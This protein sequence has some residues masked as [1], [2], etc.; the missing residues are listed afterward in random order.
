LAVSEC[1]LE[2]TQFYQSGAETS[3]ISPL[4]LAGIVIC[5]GKLEEEIE[6]QNV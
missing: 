2:E 4:S 6:T 1:V 5:V 3:T